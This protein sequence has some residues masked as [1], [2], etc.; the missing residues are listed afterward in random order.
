LIAWE[1]VVYAQFL[2]PNPFLLLLGEK[3]LDPSSSLLGCFLGV[4]LIPEH[5]LSGDELPLSISVF[6][7]VFVSSL[8][9][10][11]LDLLVEHHVPVH[12]LHCNLCHFLLCEL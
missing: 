1:L 8:H 2:K 11:A 6:E 3:P 9:H 5:D 4:E 7:R 10:V 12:C